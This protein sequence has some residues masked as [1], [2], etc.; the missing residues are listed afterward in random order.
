[1]SDN[2]IVERV[3]TLIDWL[4]FEK[5]IKNR[6]ELALKMGYTES[7]LSQILNEKVKLSDKFIKKLSEIDENINQDWILRGEGEMIFKDNVS[8][9]PAFYKTKND[10]IEYL[11]K[12]IDNLE[13]TVSVQKELIEE[14]K[15]AKYINS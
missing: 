4:I 15:K 11:Y 2:L 12:I 3:K 14:L 10:Q 5:A 8:E 9:P 7:S 1:M 13:Y 6:R